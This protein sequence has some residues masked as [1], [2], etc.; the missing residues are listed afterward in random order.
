MVLSSERQWADASFSDVRRACSKAA[1]RYGVPQVPN[2]ALSE[3]PNATL[4]LWKRCHQGRMRACAEALHQ[5]AKLAR[6][7][8]MSL[9]GALIGAVLCNRAWRL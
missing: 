2:V 7:C 9:L 8:A 4:T 3:E 5:P 1:K 6:N